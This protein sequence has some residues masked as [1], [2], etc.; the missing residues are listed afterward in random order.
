MALKS[1]YETTVCR[2]FSQPNQSKLQQALKEALIG[3]PLAQRTFGVLPIGDASAVFVSGLDPEDNT[4]PPFVHPYLIENFKGKNYLISDI[5]PFK[6]TLSLY[7]D[8]GEFEKTVRNASEY[9]LVKNRA[10]LEL[11]WVAGERAKIRSQLS[12]AGSVFGSW[13]AQSVTK[14]FALDFHDQLRVTALSIYYFHLL[15]DDGSVLK[16]RALE[17]AAI[18]T[19]NVTKLEAAEVYALFESM[20]EIQDANDFCEAIK[21]KLENVRLAEFNLAML[22]TLIRNTWYGNNAKDV[23]AT[24]LEYPPAWI[25]I[26]Y[27]AMTEKTYKN[28]PVYKLIEIQAK[29]SRNVEEFRLNY[30]GFLRRVMALETI[31]QSLVFKDFGD[32]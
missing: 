22:L 15:F 9:A 2:T 8:E 12:F 6:G 25:A 7:P 23:I 14:V 27:A 17:V 29:R 31:D 28:S 10:A 26:V 1:S 18:H 5:R 4:I 32:V 19:I 11:F 21:V 24:A 3:S 13:I 30:E 20:P 16:D